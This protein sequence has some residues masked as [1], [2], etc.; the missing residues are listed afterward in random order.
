VLVGSQQVQLTKKTKV[1]M[2]QRK[3]KCKGAQAVTS[4]EL[5]PG[6]QIL[7][8]KTR[9]VKF[10]RTRLVSCKLANSKKIVNHLRSN[11]NIG[12]TKRTRSKTHRGDRK[13]RPITYH[14]RRPRG[15]WGLDKRE[16][17]SI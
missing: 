12:K 2:K 16:N 5:T 8:S 10:N 7:H 17:T 1:K 9:S 4:V 6:S 14:D 13:I 3:A 15:M 11:K